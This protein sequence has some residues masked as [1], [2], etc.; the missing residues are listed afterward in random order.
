MQLDS[1]KPG[2]SLASW[3]KLPWG[4]PEW[5]VLPGFHTPAENGLRKAP[6]CNEIFT[7]I[8]GLMSTGV[9]TI[10]ISRCGPGGQATLDLVR[11]F[12]QELPHRPPADCWQCAVQLLMQQPL[13]MD[14]E[15]R[16]K[17]VGSGAEPP[18]ADH[19]FF[20][21]AYLLVDS[22]QLDEGKAPPPPPPINV[23]PKE[24]RRHPVT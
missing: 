20:W 11:E 13:D 2:G 6:P 7:A 5:V 3:M 10:L 14:A 16:L 12:A 8:C 15:P 18:L 9:R 4:G 21:A 23:K 22:G 17:K 1:G 24:R 19:P